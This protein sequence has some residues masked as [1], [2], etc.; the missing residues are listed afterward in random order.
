[1]KYLGQELSI[2]CDEK[3]LQEMGFKDNQI[4]YISVGMSRNMKKREF[5]DAPSMQA[6]PSR[7]CLPTLLLLKPSYFEQLFSLMHTLS[8]MKI[9]V[10]GGE[11]IPH[12]KA[13]VLSRRV[14]DILSLMPTSPKLLKGFQQL[15]I[16]LSEL[17]DPSSAQKLMYSLYIV[18]SL[19]I[20]QGKFGDDDEVPWTRKFIQHGG[21]RYLY[22]IFMS[23]VLQRD[24][25]D[26]SDWQQD[27]LASLLK[28]LC[29][30]G[31]EQ[32]PHESRPSR[33]EKIIIP[34]LNDAMMA[35]VDVKTTM[36]KLTSILKEASL[37]RDPNHYKTGFWGRAQVVHY[38]MTLLVSWLHC[39]EEARQGL[40]ESADF[41]VWFQ[42]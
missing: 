8:S 42:R 6:A 37:P 2:D 40:F 23:G 10:K 13:Q 11:V 34:S 16:S 7:D 20:R 14:W 36:P 32:L 33:N 27:C 15:N 5:L 31:L 30:L 22:D 17:L 39:S 24:S 9:V 19:S 41:S 21:L 12:T 35:L 3:T 1:M 4:T 25:G 18:E 29:H 28:L 26:G 38:A